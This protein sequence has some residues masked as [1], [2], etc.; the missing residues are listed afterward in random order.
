MIKYLLFVLL[1]YDD[2][3]ISLTTDLQILPNFMSYIFLFFVKLYQNP[4][5][6]HLHQA[7]FFTCSPILSY[8]LGISDILKFI[9]FLANV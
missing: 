8:F 6:T 1:L 5:D 2:L 7:Y 4:K 9:C 3:P